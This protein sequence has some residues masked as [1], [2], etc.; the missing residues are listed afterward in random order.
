[1]KETLPLSGKGKKIYYEQIN[2]VIRVKWGELKFNISQDIINNIIKD[3]FIDSKTWYI[4]GAGMTDPIKSGLGEYIQKNFKPLSPRHSSA[5]AAI[6]V[7]EQ[8]LDYKGLKPILLKKV[9]NINL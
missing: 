3:F 7:K 9:H 5:I 8:L 4:L 2:N 1:M 6:M